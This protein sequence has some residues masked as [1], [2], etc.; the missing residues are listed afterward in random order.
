MEEKKQINVQVPQGHQ[1][2]FANSINVNVT[3]D[4]VA[5]QFLFVRPNASQA[6]LVSEIVITPKHA[7]SFQ[8]TLDQT[9]KKHFTRHLSESDSNSS[10]S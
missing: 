1:P 3:D 7:I 6:T 10:Q 4:A 8:K 2:T 9:I 5:L